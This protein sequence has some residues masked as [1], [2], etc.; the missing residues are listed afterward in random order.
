[1]LLALAE[2]PGGGNAEPAALDRARPPVAPLRAPLARARRVARPA[3]RARAS[4]R[5]PHRKLG[6]VDRG[7]WTHTT[8]STPSCSGPTELAEV[9]AFYAHAYPG[10]WFHARMLE[11]R[12]LRRDPARR[13]AR[14]RGR[15]PRLV[16]DV[17]RRDAR[18]R[19]DACPRPAGSGLATAACAGSAGSCSRDGIDVISLNVRADNAAAIRAYEKLGFAHAADYVEVSLEP[20]DMRSRSDV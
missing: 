4:S 10:T 6:L 3:A 14:L 9:E 16:A 17:G 5:Y 12:A 7:G 15:R 13:R 2:E 18:E 1:M 8:R 11:T 19:R 20:G